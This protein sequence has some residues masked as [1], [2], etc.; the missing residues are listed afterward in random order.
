MTALRR[1]G[2][3]AGVAC[4]ALALLIAALI[5]GAAIGET[6][7]PF[8]VVAKTIANRLFDAGYELE[9]LD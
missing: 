5:A 8:S 1:N 7:I 6:S 3:K 9:P 2:W 4:T